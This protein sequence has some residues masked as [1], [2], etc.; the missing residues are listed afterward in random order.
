MPTGYW[1]IFALL[2]ADDAHP[3]DRGAVLS[4][5]QRNI[6]AA[7][8]GALADAHSA[9]RPPP[10]PHIDDALRH[11]I[12]HLDD[13]AR[14]GQPWAQH[15]GRAS[16]LLAFFDSESRL[17][18]VANT[19]AGRAFLGRRVSDVKYECVELVGPGAPRYHELEPARTRTVDVEELVNEGVFP[20]RGPLDA[21]SVEIHSVEV[22]DGDFLVLGSE[23]TWAGVEGTEAVQA[24]SEWIRVQEEPAPEGGRRPQDPI[25]SLDFP[26]KDEGD[27]FGLG[28]VGAMIPAM[29][30]NFDA[31]FSRYRGNPASC[32][33]HHTERRAASNS[34]PDQDSHMGGHPV[35]TALSSGWVTSQ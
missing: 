35:C 26:R 24:V 34:A 22:R 28:W 3:S 16:A 10:S 30:D 25:L 19:G 1:S 9:N 13:D 4:W 33:L 17:L 18:R 32:I 20:S 6:V 11:A 14:M 2:S 23:G 27:D 29:M 21:S 7:V 12:V 15:A 31:M 8:A 5:I